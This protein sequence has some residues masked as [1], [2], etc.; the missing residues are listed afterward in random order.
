MGS[1]SSLREKERWEFAV[2]YRLQAAEQSYHLQSVS[3]PYDR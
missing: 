3:T 1:S 2:V